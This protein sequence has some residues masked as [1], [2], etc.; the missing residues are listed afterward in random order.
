M[1]KVMTVL[2]AALLSV[3]LAVPAFAAST[4]VDDIIAEM[5]AGIEVDGKV[6]EIPDKYI[7]LAESFFAEN[8]LTQEELDTA[9]A[10][11]KEVKQIWA[12]TGI[13]SYVDLPADVKTTLQ[14]K[15]AESAKKVGATLTFD[16][17]TIKVVSESG[18]TYSVLATD[19]APIKPTGADYTVAVTAAVAV[20]GILAATLF[21]ARK[22]RLAEDR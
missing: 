19:D 20:L 7:D 22:N 21:V 8:E 14:N 10:D 11:L 9:L 13:Y 12:D 1:K 15:A 5:K 6:K 17:R 4:T 3:A 18:K 2:L 16:G